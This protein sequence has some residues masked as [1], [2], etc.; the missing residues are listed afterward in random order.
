M[1]YSDQ[2]HY[3]LL[4]NVLKE[5]DPFICPTLVTPPDTNVNQDKALISESLPGE[6]VC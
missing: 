6:V 5:V 1:K 3:L 4:S 2:A